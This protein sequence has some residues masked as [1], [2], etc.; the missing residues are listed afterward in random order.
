MHRLEGSTV[1]EIPVNVF[2]LACV[3]MFSC[4][5]WIG[6]VS[7]HI[8]ADPGRQQWCADTCT[9]SSLK[10]SHF[11]YVLAWGTSVLFLLSTA[12]TGKI[13]SALSFYSYMFFPLYL[14]G[15]LNRLCC[16]SLFGVGSFNRLASFPL[17]CTAAKLLAHFTHIIS[18]ERGFLPLSQQDDI[19][20]CD[21]TAVCC[22]LCASFNLSD[23]SAEYS[24]E[25][26]WFPFKHISLSYYHFSHF[27]MFSSWVLSWFRQERSW[28]QINRGFSAVSGI[29]RWFVMV[30][31]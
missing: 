5:G 6:S 9:C 2:A 8:I 18:V 29:I 13:W 27:S 10:V 11:R 30:L 19:I 14:S 16:V 26:I 28:R 23:C 21:I 22:V 17:L 7:I 3:D 12:S 25:L 15:Y 1:E 24:R 20:L 4:V 31:C